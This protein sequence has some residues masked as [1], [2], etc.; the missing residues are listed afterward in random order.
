MV[1]GTVAAGKYKLLRNSSGGTI[2]VNAERAH[3]AQKNV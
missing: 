2:S 1:A 3:I